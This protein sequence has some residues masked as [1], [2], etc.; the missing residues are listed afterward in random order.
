MQRAASAL[1][2]QQ[3]EDLAAYYG[4]LDAETQTR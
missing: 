4:S 3:I 2:E 1:S